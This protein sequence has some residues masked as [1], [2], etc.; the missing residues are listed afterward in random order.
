MEGIPIIWTEIT[1]KQLQ[2]IY[3][4]IAEESI[5]HADRVFEKLLN[6]TSELSK[7]PKKFPPDKYKYNNDGTY[8]AYELYHFRISYKI[9]ETAIYIVRIRSVFQN[10]QEY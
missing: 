6:S 4:F 5:Y 10:P 3:F 9:T 7:H 8:R 1:K 2:E